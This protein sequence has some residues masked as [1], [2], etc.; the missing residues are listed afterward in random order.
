MTARASRRATTAGAAALPRRGEV[1]RGG[2]A[3]P[4]YATCPTTSSRRAQAVA[5]PTSSSSRAST[6]C[7]PAARPTARRRSC[8]CRTSST[9]PSTSMPRRRTSGAGTSSASSP[10]GR[11]RSRRRD[12]FHRFADLTD[13][14]APGPRSNLDGGQRAQPSG[15]T[16]RPT[17]S[18]ARLILVKAPTTGPPGPACASSDGLPD[19][20]RRPSTY[21]PP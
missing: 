3:A 8:S 15:A 19:A 5:G 11:R 16:S 21:P 18:R 14:Q 6:S 12:Y 20:P 2:V 13:E 7:R 4:V 1:R 9:S 10:C 17:S